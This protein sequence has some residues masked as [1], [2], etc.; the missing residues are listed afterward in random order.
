[1]IVV[2]F[3]SRLREDANL[4][5]LSVLYERLYALVSAMPG[6]IRVKDFQ[7]SDGEAVSIA[8]F[9]TLEHMTAWREH[10]E[11][12]A[13]QERGRQEFFKEY[14]IQVCTMVRDSHFPPQ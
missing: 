8:E 11:H 12:K 4:A 13:A 7:A 1:M 2:I 3:R 14:T 6:F 9:D 5:E 10:P